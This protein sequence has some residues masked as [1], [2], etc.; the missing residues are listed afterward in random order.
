MPGQTPPQFHYMTALDPAEDGTD[1]ALEV[2][3]GNNKQDVDFTLAPDGFR[4][5]TVTL[6]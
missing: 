5:L 2:K 4:E 1:Y 6:P 3:V